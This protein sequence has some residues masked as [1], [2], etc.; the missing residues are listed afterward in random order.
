MDRRLSRSF[1]FF[2]F[3][4]FL[5]LALSSCGGSG[6]SGGNTRALTGTLG[7]A[8]KLPSSSASTC[9]MT[10][11]DEKIALDGVTVIATATNGT[12]V[13][14]ETNADGSFTLPLTIGQSYVISFSQGNT[15]L[16]TLIV[17]LDENGNFKSRGFKIT[18]GDGDIALG[19]VIC[20]AGVCT[21]EINPNCELDDNED[22]VVNCK[23]HGFKD[24]HPD[25]DHDG[26][27]DDEQGE[28]H[29]EDEDA[30]EVTEIEPFNGELGVAVDEAIEIHFSHAID[31]G[32]LDAT[33]LFL[34]ADADGA[35]IVTTIARGGDSEREIELVPASPLAPLTSY[36]I[37][38]AGTVQCLN[39]ASPLSDVV[40][41]FTT[42]TANP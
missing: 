18:D 35:V 4:I 6:N 13:T 8:N 11:L 36:T 32:T 21:A 25:R 38:L 15:F 37:H 31:I 40:V 14:A 42:G 17:S 23:D 2:L 16:G 7:S 33:S 41:H 26:I 10:F 22:G 9:M 34:T 19:R 3:S 39:G 27:C 28:D 20:S 12:T 5:A 1:Y 24:R 30:C 29:P